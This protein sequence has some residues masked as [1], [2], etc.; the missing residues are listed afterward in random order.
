MARISSAVCLLLLVAL[1]T[2]YEVQGTFL[3]RHFLRKIP[4]RSRGLRPFA[5]KGM[6]KFVNLLE[7]K[8][9]LKPVYKNLFG[10]LRS[11]VGAI[12]SGSNVDLK[13]KAEGVQSALSALGGTSGSSVKY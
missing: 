13:G 7:L 5:C 3:L 11:Y 6:L 2:V 10:N 1:S 4:R 12:S 9:P 8:C